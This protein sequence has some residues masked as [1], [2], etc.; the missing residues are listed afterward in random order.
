MGALALMLVCM[1]SQAK[2]G[3]TFTIDNLTYKVL[4]ENA[5]TQTGTVS[6]A[7]ASSSLTGMIVVPASVSNKNVDYAVTTI[8][9]FANT[10]IVGMEIPATA[11]TIAAGNLNN[12]NMAT[13]SV[14]EDNP[15][16]KTV[17]NVLYN[18]NMTQ[19]IY[20]PAARE[21]TEFHCPETV[22]QINNYAFQYAN[23][24]K[25][26]MNEGL[27]SINNFAFDGATA[28]EWIDVP[29]TL[30]T[31][32]SCAFRFGTREKN[33]VN[34]N[35]HDL[36]SF[37]S[38]N[39]LTSNPGFWAAGFANSTESTIWI[40]GQ[41]ITDLVIPADITIVNPYV[42][43]YCRGLNSV[44]FE[45]NIE[46][47]YHNAFNSCWLTKIEFKGTCGEIQSNAFYNHDLRED[48]HLPDG[49]TSI[50]QNAFGLPAPQSN[51][52]VNGSEEIFANRNLPRINVYVPEGVTMIGKYAF[53]HVPINELHLPTTLEEIKSGAFRCLDG[54]LGKCK[55]LYIND[56]KSWLN[57]KMTY[58]TQIG[59]DP[60]YFCSPIDS[61]WWCFLRGSYYL[62]GSFPMGGQENTN[63]SWTATE[64]WK[65]ETP[66]PRIATFS[67]L[68]INNQLVTNLV[69]PEGTTKINRG[70]FAGCKSLEN[71]TLPNT[72]EY[73]DEYA[74]Y[75]CPNIRV[76]K[77]PNSVKH[78]GPS[79]FDEC[80]AM[81]H[82]TMPSYATAIGPNVVKNMN[83]DLLT[84]FT[85]PAYTEDFFGAKDLY[86]TPFTNMS[87]YFMG[88]SIPNKYFDDT[89]RYR[90][91]YADG[92]R[93]T[94]NIVWSDTIYVGNETRYGTF[95][96]GNR[97]FKRLWGYPHYDMQK[98]YV[99]KSV[100]NKRY[101]DGKWRGYD[102]S[103]KV[104]VSMTNAAGNPIEYKTLCRDFDV[105]LTH[106]NDDLP[107]GVEPLRAYLVED[108]EGELRMVFLNEIKYIPSR[109]K[110][111]VTDEDGNLYQGVD[112]YVG[113]VLR[114]TPGYTYYYEIGEHDYTQGA[115]GQWLMDD[116]MA[117]SNGTFEQNLMA[118]D[119]NDD[120]YVHMTV[121]NENN[122]EIVNYG[123]NAGKFK[124]YHKDGWL[125]YNKSYLQLP[126]DVSAAIENNTDEEGNANLTFIFNNAD[127]S[128]D[129]VSSVEFNRNCESDIFYNPYG[130]RVSKDT[131][132]IVINNG[133]KYVNK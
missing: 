25:I 46:R 81:T 101:P 65:K 118:G 103:Y 20:Y 19:I 129:K 64:G 23:I 57:V 130:Q 91:K 39:I 7:P 127:G 93:D 108:V 18:K 87:L 74:F 68:Y 133:K 62:T 61:Y 14:D 90:I 84:E 13:V 95:E 106:T 33:C 36:K 75:E 102:V 59:Q 104:P 24:E 100:Y 35:I 79:A 31:V 85:V 11:T 92:T 107:E 98:L 3:D 37:C 111:N 21:E 94:L 26:F 120:F 114:G 51:N 80:W 22:E 123:L 77:I 44:T 10:T 40:N 32:G 131:K 4:S 12:K 119:A 73:I 53:A 8:G 69:I 16:F 76:L 110:A 52:G 28:L 27:V 105:D 55:A 17:D 54:L 30:Q 34:V 112:E 41:R 128:T 99:K 70:A 50:A 60:N 89:R 66:I 83:T 132:G 9:N 58:E 125:T 56:L 67:D 49:L 124:I 45:G 6:V 2:K 97:S 113:V 72:L 116:A 88:D 1:T 43:Y 117:Y 47:I 121:E 15:Y 126:K 29:T 96:T 122:D 48:L 78:I 109:L 115:E 63:N 5:T 42:F 86:Y 71:V 82:I 38:L